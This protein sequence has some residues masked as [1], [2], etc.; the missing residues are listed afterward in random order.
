MKTRT[1][2]EKRAMGEEAVSAISASMALGMPGAEVCR[3]C[4]IKPEAL[5]RYLGGQSFPPPA[6]ALRILKGLR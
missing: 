2:A 3:R 4:G 1:A 5:G 6:R